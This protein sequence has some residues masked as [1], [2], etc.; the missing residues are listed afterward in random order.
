[1]IFVADARG[2]IFPKNVWFG[3]RIIDPKS[4]HAAVRP[5]EHHARH[6]SP[7]RRQVLTPEIQWIEVFVFLRRI[8]REFN[9][10]VG[11]LIKPF[12]MFANVRMIRRTIDREIERDLHSALADFAVQPFEIL[13]RTEGRFD[14]L[15]SSSLASNCPRHAWIA[16]L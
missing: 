13:Q 12:R 1:W 5:K 4:P 8:L 11:T 16:R 3:V 9:R 2:Q 15:V 10:A 14:R 7:K 6:L